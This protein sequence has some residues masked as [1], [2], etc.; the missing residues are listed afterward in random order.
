MKILIFTSCIPSEKIVHSSQSAVH[1]QSFYAIQEFLKKHDISLQIIFDESR[2]NT[3]LDKWEKNLISKLNKKIKILNPI[4]LS[5]LVFF[6]KLPNLLKKILYE[7]NVYKNYKLFFYK[8]DYFKEFKDEYDFFISYLSPES[9]ALISDHKTRKLTFEGDLHYQS[10]SLTINS[11]QTNSLKKKLIKFYSKFICK[12][13]ESIYLFLLKDFNRV[14]AANLNMTLSLRGKLNTRFIGTLWPE[15]K[16]IK[17]YQ[18]TKKLNIILGFGNSSNTASRNAIVY[19]TQ[20]LIP[21]IY[22]RIN[23][24]NVNFIFMSSGKISS[25]EKNSFL[26]INTTIK[27]WVE[28]L[29][30]ELLDSDIFVFMNNAGPSKAIFSRQIYVY[31]I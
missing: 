18:K 31:F 29:D 26:K 4:F 14:F 16:I 10:F 3:V 22:K 30:K 7:N 2:T 17:K 27:G 25:E 6:D 21:V 13:W 15:S 11:L 12:M 19:L 23:Y 1:I 5:K 28:D 20:K 8:K 9:I 24:S